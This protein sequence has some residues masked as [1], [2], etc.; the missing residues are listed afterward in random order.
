M[1]GIDRVTGA[2][3]ATHAIPIGRS[4]SFFTNTS[5]ATPVADW[6]PAIKPAGRRSSFAVSNKLRPRASLGA[7]EPAH[8]SRPAGIEPPADAPQKR[9]AS[10]AAV[11]RVVFVA[12][13]RK[14]RAFDLWRLV[15]RGVR[16]GPTSPR[17]GP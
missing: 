9:G 15:D 5:T 6:A 14:A 10:D 4:S 11:E 17:V 16:R 3:P 12:A 7:R 13:G 8:S 2:T 1:K